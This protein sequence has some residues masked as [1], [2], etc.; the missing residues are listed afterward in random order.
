MGDHV[1][2]ISPEIR[3]EMMKHALDS[4]PNEACGYLAGRSGL[5]QQYFPIRNELQS[6]VA[7][8][9]DSADQLH[10]ED[11]IQ[12]ADLEILGIFHSHPT[13]AAFP[14]PT[15]CA[16]LYLSERSVDGEYYLVH[17]QALRVIA[18]FRK[19]RSPE[20]RAFRILEEVVVT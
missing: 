7:F 4:L 5:V 6:P 19:K 16:N 3:A 10:A 15:D 13:S 18:S 14:S 12:A 8:R 11:A 20:L 2:Q 1:I 17:P 9:M